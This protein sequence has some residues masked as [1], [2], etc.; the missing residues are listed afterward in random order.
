MIRRRQLMSSIYR[1]FHRIITTGKAGGV[2]AIIAF[3]VYSNTLLHEFTQDDAIV[4]YENIY[5]KEGIK[6]IPDIFANDSF[7]G[8]FQGQ[9]K[10]NLVSGGRYRPLS[11]GFFA[12]IYQFFG[13]STF[14]YHFLNV[15][16]Y[17]FLC[18]LLYH[19][20]I[21]LGSEQ[22]KSQASTFAFITALIFAVH[23]IHTEVVANVKGLDEIF[24][25]LFALSACWFGIRS[26]T[27]KSW[28]YT[29]FM[30]TSFG[31]ALLSKENA[32]PFLLIIPATLY[33]FL[34]RIS[35]KKALLFFSQL[36]LVFIMYMA[37]R[38]A[39][40]GS[41]FSS[42]VSELM[43]NPFLK[44]V[45]GNYVDFTF[46]EKTASIT[47]GLGKN[48]QLMFFPHPLT[49]DYYPRHFELY[50]LNSPEVLLSFIM[51]LSLILITLKGIFKKAFSAYYISYFFIT[52]FLTSNILFPIG[53]HLSERFLFTPSIGFGLFIA[54]AFLLFHK[55]QK[56]RWVYPIMVIYV[57]LL[58]FKTISRN[59]VWKNDFTL[60]TTDVNTSPNSAKVRNAAGG[61]MIAKSI[62]ITNSEQQQELLDNA[63]IHLNEATSI[64][65]KYKEA[66]FLKGN[67]FAYLNNY[68]AAILSYEKALEINPYYD[69][70]IQNLNSVLRSAATY[71]GSQKGDFNRSLEYLTKAHQNNPTEFETLSLL[72][73]AWGSSGNHEKAIQFFELAIQQKPNVATTYVNLGI[74][75]SNAGKPEDANLQFTKALELDP[76]ALDGLK[77]K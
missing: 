31:L 25:L 37:I 54:H 32:A 30:C 56:S 70:A 3:L 41:N 14:I 51:I 9:Q 44:V 45:D 34:P 4:I 58:S 12:L 6:G 47:Y 55:L 60:F 23:P 69:P 46:S 17:G 36:S 29:L 18:F 59:V 73:T 28:V 62:E 66:H 71:F 77:L 63:I 39:I 7:S 75:L 35:I 8:F 15:I 74:A 21:R 10:S 13:S 53:T 19:V 67:A 24:S 40:V 42:T 76:K 72:G 16:F 64:H 38:H 2:I 52:I 61:A 20:I 68:D 49:H 65:P 33:I 11:I 43:N 26:T 57:A 50:K 5:V 27:Q 22:K 48:I 1:T